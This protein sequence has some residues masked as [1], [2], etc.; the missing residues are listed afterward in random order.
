[1]MPHD[2]LG[3]A[4]YMTAKATLSLKTFTLVITLRLA[5]YNFVHYS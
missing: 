2:A 5:H 1:M 3:Y 4:P